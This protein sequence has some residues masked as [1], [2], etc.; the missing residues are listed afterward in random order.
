MR[1]EIPVTVVN[2]ETGKRTSYPSY[3]SAA[4]D[5]NVAF[6]TIKKMVKT[7]SAY[8]NWYAYLSGHDHLHKERIAYFTAVYA[9][10]YKEHTVE[11][12]KMAKRD[13]MVKMNADDVLVSLR[14]DAHT[15]IMVPRYKATE[16]YAQK[17]RERLEKA[18]K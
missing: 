6:L 15:V 7:K 8:K 1:Q 10:R 5:I 11:E 14:I 2:L 17:Y 3:S 9:D 13:K 18:R 12:G 4:N 16:Q